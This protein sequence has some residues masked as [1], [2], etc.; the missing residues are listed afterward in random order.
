M[1]AM[2]RWQFW[3]GVVISLVFLYLALRGLHL[4]DVWGALKSA[5]LVVAAWRAGIF[6]RRMGA[7]LAVALSF[8]PGETSFH[9]PPVPD[10]YHRVHG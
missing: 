3:L 9:S 4:Q 2:K 5:L 10:R 7:R 8:T 6:P 1:S